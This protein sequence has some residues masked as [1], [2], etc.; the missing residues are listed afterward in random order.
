MEKNKQILYRVRFDRVIIDDK[1]TIKEIEDKPSIVIKKIFSEKEIE[2]MA[3]IWGNADEKV[4]DDIVKEIK[5]KLLDI[6]SK[7]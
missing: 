1:G 4:L 7:K 6:H 3:F 2:A 5:E